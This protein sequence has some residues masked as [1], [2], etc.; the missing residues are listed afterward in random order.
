VCSS[1]LI[2]LGLVTKVKVV[3]FVYFSSTQMFLQN[4]LGKLARG[5]QGKIASERKHK[6]CVQPA[7]LKQ[8]QLFGSWRNQLQPGVRPQNARRMRFESNRRRPD[9]LRSRASH[10]FVEHMTVS[11]MHA[12]KIADAHQRRPKAS[13]NILEFAEDLHLKSFNRKG[14]KDITRDNT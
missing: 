6:H 5:H 14:R 2:A 1:D 4:F 11:S 12:V 13:G 3:A 8:A 10:D 7:G 9:T